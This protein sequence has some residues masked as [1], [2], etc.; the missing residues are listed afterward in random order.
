MSAL[1][2]EPDGNRFRLA[3]WG[4]SHSIVT[5]RRDHGAPRPQKARCC[6]RSALA[7]SAFRHIGRPERTGGLEWLAEDKRPRRILRVFTNVRTATR[8]LERDYF[9]IA[10]FG[11]ARIDRRERISRKGVGRWSTDD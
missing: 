5:D 1:T 8:N 4:R 2:D 9:P 11:D 10:K 3:K 6:G 7:E